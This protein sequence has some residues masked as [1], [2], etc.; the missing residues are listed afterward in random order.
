MMEVDVDL[1]LLPLLRPLPFLFLDFPLKTS[2]SSFER[3][4]RVNLSRV[5]TS[6]VRF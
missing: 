4:A 3:F 5:S 1:D 6:T 2:E